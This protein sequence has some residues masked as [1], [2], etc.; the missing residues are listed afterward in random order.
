MRKTITYHNNT[1]IIDE[2]I[3]KDPHLKSLFEEIDHVSITRSDN[4]FLSLVGSIISQQLSG[5]VADVIYNRFLNHYQNDVTPLKVI[6]TDD[7]DLRQLGISYQK[8]SYLKSLSSMI[9]SGEI[10]IEDFIHLN[11]ES[12]IE[13]LI[14]VKGIGRWTA[15][16]FL[17]FSLGRED[18]AAPLDLGLRKAY[19][20]LIDKEVSV[21]EFEQICEKWIPYRSIVSFFLWKSTDKPKENKS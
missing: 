14:K 17:M 2:L 12:I 4:Y 7:E 5:K 3:Q 10:N 15:Q 9:V 13:E 1:P 6:H 16:M 18:V 11:D 21:K 19:S 8:I 20:R